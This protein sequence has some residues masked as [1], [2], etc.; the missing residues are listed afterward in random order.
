MYVRPDTN[1]F[2]QYPLQE[3]V[4]QFFERDSCLRGGPYLE[5]ATRAYKLTEGMAPPDL[6]AGLAFDEL[7]REIFSDNKVETRSQ[8]LVEGVRRYMQTVL[9]R[10]FERECEDCPALLKEIDTI[11]VGEFIKTKENKTL[12]VVS[13]AI[14]TGL[15]WAFTLDPLC[16]ETIAGVQEMVDSERK[17]TLCS[18][19]SVGIVP[20]YFIDYMTMIENK[21][22][23]FAIYKLQV[24]NMSDSTGYNSQSV[25][26]N[27]WLEVL[28]AIELCRACLEPS[29]KRYCAN[30]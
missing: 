10:L 22:E 23:E 7:F 21:R 25:A 1:I 12:E 24:C 8:G 18:S 28:F 6:R 15:D 26:F 13:N 20:G 27:V 16:L 30:A 3:V 14:K 2:C 19:S 17:N 29:T 5:K 9:R 11:L 4:P